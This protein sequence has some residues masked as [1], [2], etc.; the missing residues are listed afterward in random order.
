[1]EASTT[2]REVDKHIISLSCST[3]L[4]RLEL[5]E[6]IVNWQPNFTTAIY[7]HWVKAVALIL[8]CKLQRYF[9]I[10]T[11]FQ[12]SIDNSGGWCAICIYSETSQ[13]GPPME[14]AKMVQLEGWST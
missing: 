9:K 7:L 10:L 1:M 8:L 12:N 6:G 4:N 2:G 3:S 5:S 13:S 11:D 14:P